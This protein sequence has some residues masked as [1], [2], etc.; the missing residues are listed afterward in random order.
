[1]TDRIY[2]E[3]VRDWPDAW[4]RRYPAEL[5]RHTRKIRSTNDGL[6]E[7]LRAGQGRPFETLVADFQTRGRGRRGDRWE[8][9]A[10]RSLLFSIALPLGPDRETWSRLPH[11]AA[12]FAGTAIES[13][14]PEGTRIAAKWPNDLLLKGRKIG[15]ILVET[16]TNPEPFAVVGIGLNV[17]TRPE[18]FPVELREQATSLYERLGCESSRWFLLGLVLREFL[19]GYPDK[20]TNY[21]SIHRWISDR[22]FLLGKSIRLETSAGTVEGTGRGLAPGGELLVES[23]NGEIAAVMSAERIVFC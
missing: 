4:T 21:E 5:F 18:E 9:P 8:A 13:V 11:L 15:G 3:V 17:N 1:M 19:A 22:D 20:L 2:T 23:T 6:L 12:C 10:E 16:V 14:L 7:I